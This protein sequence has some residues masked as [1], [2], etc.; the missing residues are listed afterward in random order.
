MSD[1][2]VRLRPLSQQEFDVWLAASIID[3]AADKVA[4]GN[5]TQE[6][7]VARSQADY[8]RLLLDGLATPQHHFFAIVHDPADEQVGVAWLAET[9]FAKPAVFLYDFVIFEPYRRRGYALQALARLEDEAK[10]LGMSGIALHVFGHN[11]AARA[12]YEKAGFEITN[13]NMRKRF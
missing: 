7:A 13:I 9:D 5:W 8:A 1:D 4:A 10:K 12:L 11:Q 2:S 3:Y 6:E